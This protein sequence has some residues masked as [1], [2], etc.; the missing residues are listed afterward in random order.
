MNIKKA[1]SRAVYSTTIAATKFLMLPFYR[2]SKSKIETPKNEPFIGIANHASY[3]DAIVI[4]STI[5]RPMRFVMYWKIYEL[6]IVK[7]FFKA[8]GAIPI[9]SPRENREVYKRAVEEMNAEIERGGAIF[10]FPEGQ[11]TYDGHLNEFKSG[12]IRL[13]Q[14]RKCQIIPFGIKG[15]WGSVFSRAKQRTTSI[16]RRNISVTGGQPIPHKEVT[17]ARLEQEVV[18]LIR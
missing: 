8:L 13:S 6:P 7:Y 16:L 3:L 9:A 5:K 11:I 12:A 10:I 1:M 4:A 15:V 14:K 18:A 2:V 17:Q